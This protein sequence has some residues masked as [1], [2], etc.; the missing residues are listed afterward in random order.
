MTGC[1]TNPEAHL[2]EAESSPDLWHGLAEVLG[3]FADDLEMKSGPAAVGEFK[4]NVYHKISEA[5][6]T[7]YDTCESWYMPDQT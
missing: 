6:K 3:Q 1:K 4:D 5:F 7:P 2:E